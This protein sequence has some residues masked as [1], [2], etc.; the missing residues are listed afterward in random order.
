EKQLAAAEQAVAAAQ[1]A[2]AI[3]SSDYTPLSPRYPPVSSGRRTALAQWIASRD[4]PLT[5]RVAVN[6][7]WGWHFG[8]PLVESTF[9]FG[10][11]G[12]APSHPELLD[13]LA[14]EFMDGGWKMKPLHHLIVTSNAYRQRSDLGGTTDHPN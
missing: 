6:Y 11:N 7:L 4:N 9:D 5:A 14:V 3:E 12:K 8:R 1:K 2:V 10:R 13:W